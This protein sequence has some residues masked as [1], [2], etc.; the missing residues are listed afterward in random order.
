MTSSWSL[1]LQLSKCWVFAG[2]NWFWI[3]RRG[4]ACTY[5]AGKGLVRRRT[6]RVI[7]WLHQKRY[8]SVRPSFPAFHRF[9]FFSFFLPSFYLLQHYSLLSLVS[10]VLLS[11]YFF[12]FLQFFGHS[13][14]PFCSF[15]TPS[16]FAALLRFP[17]IRSSVSPRIPTGS[18]NAAYL[19]CF[20]WLWKSRPQMDIKTTSC[21]FSLTGINNTKKRKCSQLYLRQIV[22]T[23][24]P[25]T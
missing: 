24:T 3:Q 4:V 19:H 13:Y 6:T 12:N 17:A 23:L 8:P 7:G 15:L 5:I 20:T 9:P 10:Y 1:I 11:F 21:W 14:I 16:F 2:Q 22:A 25:R 18:T